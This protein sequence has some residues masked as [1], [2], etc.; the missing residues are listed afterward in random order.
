MIGGAYIPGNGTEA[1]RVFRTQMLTTAMIKP[2]KNKMRADTFRVEWKRLR[3]IM[4][5]INDI[6]KLS[7]QCQ[8]AK[9]H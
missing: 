2:K 6:T 5:P 3:I 1:D 8:E 4:R 9:S 7:I